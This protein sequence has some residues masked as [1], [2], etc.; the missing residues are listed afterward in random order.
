M[1]T[2][3]SARIDTQYLPLVDEYQD[4]IEAETGT[5]PSRSLVVNLLFQ[6][7]FGGP[8]TAASAASESEAATAERISS[9]LDDIAAELRSAGTNVSAVYIKAARDSVMA[10]AEGMRT[11][12]QALHMAKG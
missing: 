2:V 7:Y 6:R 8:S 4:M 12:A 1:A 3:F 11:A 9:D 10:A 5:R